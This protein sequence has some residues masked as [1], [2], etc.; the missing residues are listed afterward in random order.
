MVAWKLEDT[1]DF[2]LGGLGN[3]RARGPENNI[4]SVCCDQT[5]AETE[6]GLVASILD[7]L[8]GA[9]LFAELSPSPTN[10][11]RSDEYHGGRKN[12]VFMWRQQRDKAT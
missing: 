3:N 12:I 5:Q 11:T 10:S 7:P 9:G 1:G 6:V 8:D 4:I 2:G